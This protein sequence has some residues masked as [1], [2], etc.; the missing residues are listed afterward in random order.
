MNTWKGVPGRYKH[1][2]IDFSDTEICKVCCCK[3]MTFF[4]PFWTMMLQDK[5]PTGTPASDIHPQG[6]QQVDIHLL[7]TDRLNTL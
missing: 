2:T 1:F 5:Q 4:K 3:L 6:E 7:K